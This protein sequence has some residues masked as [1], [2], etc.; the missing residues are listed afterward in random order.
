VNNIFD[1]CDALLMYQPDKAT[2]P[3]YS[4]K[5][6]TNYLSLLRY[7]VDGIKVHNQPTLGKR[8]YPR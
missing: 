6:L 4:I 1:N 8:E 2:V 7:F 5:T 3:S